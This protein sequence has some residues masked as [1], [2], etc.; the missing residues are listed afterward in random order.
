MLPKS[1]RLEIIFFPS[2]FH[3]LHAHARLCKN[4]VCVRSSAVATVVSL[5]I[6]ISLKS[7]VDAEK[8]KDNNYNIAVIGY[9]L[10][11][12]IL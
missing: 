11:S 4:I 7:I 6:H 12:G 1:S 3:F 9:S 10:L 2:P 5:S 8:V